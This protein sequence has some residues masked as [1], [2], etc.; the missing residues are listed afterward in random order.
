MG[1]SDLHHGRGHNHGAGNHNRAFALGVALNTIYVGFEAA[2]GLIV[3]SLALL[4]DAG[5]N[6]SDVLSLLLAWGAAR[7]GKTAP[8]LRR[9]YGLRRITI[10]ASLAN[11][12]LLLIV[13]G[14]IGW[15]AVGRLASPRSVPGGALIWVAGLGVL[16][17]AAT[18]LMFLKGRHRDLNIKGAFLHMAADAAV[19]LG[20]VIAGVL[21]KLTG[22]LW[23][24][25][26]LSLLIVLVIAAGTWGLLRDSFN[27]A[28]DAVPSGIDPRAVE[29]YLASLPGVREVHDLHVWAMST[30][31]VA[32][33]AHLVKPDGKLD[34]ALL[35]K[36]AAELRRRF[37]VHHAVLQ[38]EQG[39]E[40]CLQA[41]CGAS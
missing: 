22:Q 7:L 26:A 6:A 38:F 32:L 13:V 23:I 29:N 14:A 40:A 28:V 8:T 34:D 16:I 20:V 31:E 24:D 36:A 33:T 9:T 5:H 41:A 4:A 10:L 37:G 19:S 18:A 25:P 30:T 1:H 15:E 27:L 11:A 21:I 35:E 39:R 12:V 3:G 2:T 17:N